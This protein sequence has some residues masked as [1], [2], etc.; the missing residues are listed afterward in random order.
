VGA[1]H[2]LAEAD[3]IIHTHF[4]H[5]YSFEVLHP[6]YAHTKKMFRIMV[7]GGGVEPP[8]Y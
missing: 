7:P 8:R 2:H 6:K 1:D 5:T 4:M 3:E